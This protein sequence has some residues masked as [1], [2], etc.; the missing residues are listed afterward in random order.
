MFKQVFR[1][2]PS[3]ASKLTS[4]R[5]M[6]VLSRP[7]LVDAS[8][9]RLGASKHSPFGG[10]SCSMCSAPA[11]KDAAAG[12]K[13]SDL[14]KA[15]MDKNRY[16]EDEIA[17]LR[18]QLR[19]SS[20][21]VHHTTE[22]KAED[23]DIA[24][25]LENN[26]KWVEEQHRLDPNF[27]HKI[28]APQSP[29][30]LYIGCSDSR[31]PANQILGLGPGEVFVHRNVGNQVN[32]SDL[33]CLSAIEFA[34][35]FLGVKH[36]IVAGHYDCGA[37]RASMTKQD[38]G[39]LENWIR[40]IRD[41]YRIHHHSMALVE[42]PEE[43]HKR[44]VEYNVIEQC[45]NLYKTGV[46]QKTRMECIKRGEQQAYPRVHAMVFDPKVGLLRKLPVNFKKAI[47]QFKDIYD[48]Y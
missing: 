26:K 39:L 44:M 8:G 33:N 24:K 36:I 21:S 37:V 17:K 25:L 22:G 9:S 13:E 30:Y 38:L 5:G 32:G 46:V 14:L 20:S 34:V 42:D 45:L 6:R 1:C 2:L 16:L 31:V 19:Q 12:E 35:K 23:P 18:V 41:V 4:T 7:P 10:C 27:F 48:M 3:N 29:K 43:R 47:S 11:G 15:T 28:G 40:S